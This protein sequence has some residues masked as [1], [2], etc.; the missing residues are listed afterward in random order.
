MTHRLAFV[1]ATFVVA[2]V[3][4]LPPASAAPA[5]QPD[6]VTACLEAE[7]ETGGFGAK[8]IGLI[9]DPCIEAS[10]EKT[11]SP[12]ETKACARRELT[13]W[14]GLLRAARERVKSGGFN[15]IQT[16]VNAA[17]ASLAQSIARLCPVFDKVDPGTAPGGSDY[18]QLHETARRVLL[19]RRLGD[20]INEH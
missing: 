15:D 6:A 5:Q 17:Q 7:G 14:Q 20:A 8:C 13:I 4:T 12:T 2:T 10:Q 3:L 11:N 9:A 19:L 16:A 18:C 1:V